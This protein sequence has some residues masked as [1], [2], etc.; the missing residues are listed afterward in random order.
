MTRL[1]AVVAL[2]LLTGPALAQFFPP[3]PARSTAPAAKACSAGLNV[4][5]AG[6][7]IDLAALNIDLCG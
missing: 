3:F 6:L 2:A 4:D 7:N 5:L 1:A